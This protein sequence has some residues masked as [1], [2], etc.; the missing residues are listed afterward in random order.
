MAYGSSL[1]QIGPFARSV[2]DAARVLETIGGHD[3]G[4]STSI[5]EAFPS[6]ADHLDDGVAGKRVGILTEMMGDGISGD[7]AAG[8]RAAADA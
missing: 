2:A 7:V 1:D 6:L 8:V 5:P 3:P 4:D